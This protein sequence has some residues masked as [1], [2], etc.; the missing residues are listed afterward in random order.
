MTTLLSQVSHV[1]CGGKAILDNGSLKTLDEALLRTTTLNW[2][3]RILAADSS[4]PH[5][6][7]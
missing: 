7:R 6:K 2:Q 5:E 3:K 4:D 1:W